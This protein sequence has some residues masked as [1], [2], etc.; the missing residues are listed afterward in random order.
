MKYQNRLC[1]HFCEAQILRFKEKLM[2]KASLIEPTSR[3]AGLGRCE[4]EPPWK[5][6]E[7]NIPG[8]STYKE[9]HCWQQIFAGTESK[10]A[11]VDGKQDKAFKKLENLLDEATQRTV[12]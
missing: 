10:D 9:K 7:T 1:D 8:L 5:T 4:I 3:K 2:E 11:A 6:D 12:R